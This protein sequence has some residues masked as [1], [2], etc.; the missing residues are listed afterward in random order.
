[1]EDL[2]MDE[3]RLKAYEAIKTGSLSEYVSHV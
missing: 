2:S 3:V 1:M